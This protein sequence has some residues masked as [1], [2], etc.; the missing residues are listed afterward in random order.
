LKQS[1]KKPQILHSVIYKALG[2][3]LQTD[4][5]KTVVA[6]SDLKKAFDTAEESNPGFAEK[7]CC[8]RS[9]KFIR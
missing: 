3:L 9:K 6:I 8:K 5:E 2:H 4:D 7:I 1:K